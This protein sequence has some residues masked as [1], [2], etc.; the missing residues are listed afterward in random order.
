[1]GEVFILITMFNNHIQ[2]KTIYSLITIF[3][4]KFTNPN[5]CFIMSNRVF[6][7]FIQQLATLKKLEL[8]IDL[9]KTPRFSHY[10]LDPG[11]GVARE[12][13]GRFHTL[14]RKMNRKR[15]RFPRQKTRERGEIVENTVKGAI[16]SNSSVASPQN[17]YF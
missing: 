17:P 7:K 9:N 1:M 16:F 14:T 12:N 11:S 3:C 6:E 15:Q 5:N 10:F 8:S 2:F 13:D 4:L